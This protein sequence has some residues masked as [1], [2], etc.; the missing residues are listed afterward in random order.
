MPKSN[1]YALAALRERRA[2]LSGEIFQLALLYPDIMQGPF[3][4][5]PD[6]V[7]ETLTIPTFKRNTDRLFGFQ[8]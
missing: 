8:C 5:I 1:Q 2:K 3:L 4:V 7:P 6:R